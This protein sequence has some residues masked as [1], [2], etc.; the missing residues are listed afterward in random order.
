M[1]CVPN[2]HSKIGTIA[3]PERRQAAC[4]GWA[5]PRRRHAQTCQPCWRPRAL[6]GIAVEGVPFQLR[7]ARWRSDALSAIT[8]AGGARDPVP[9]RTAVG[10]GA[11]DAA[12]GRSR[13]RPVQAMDAFPAMALGCLIRTRW[14]SGHVNHGVELCADRSSHGLLVPAQRRAHQPRRT[15]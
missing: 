6:P 11:W 8:S 9:T 4:A 1:A 15:I 12:C 7:W 5:A 14:R 13:R 3:S 10:C 2:P